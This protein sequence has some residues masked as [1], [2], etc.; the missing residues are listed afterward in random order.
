MPQIAANLSVNLQEWIKKL[1]GKQ[2]AGLDV[3]AKQKINLA[4]L[5]A[6]R[7]YDTIH[8]RTY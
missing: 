6:Y 7:N 1:L 2:S 8:R 3:C 4:G 5:S